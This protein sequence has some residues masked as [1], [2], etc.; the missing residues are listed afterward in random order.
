M[1]IA[2]AAATNPSIAEGKNKVLRREPAYEITVTALYEKESRQ[3]GAPHGR[4]NPGSIET[5][6]QPQK[7]YTRTV[8]HKNTSLH[9]DI[10]FI[11]YIHGRRQTHTHEKTVE[12]NITMFS[13]TTKCRSCQGK[14]NGVLTKQLK[15]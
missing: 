14:T 9:I 13:V 1:T 4:H 11:I 15:L 2:V 7:K 6:H 8:P 3:K 10:S 5:L 12:R